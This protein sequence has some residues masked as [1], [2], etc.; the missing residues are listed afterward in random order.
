MQNKAATACSFK[1]THAAC[2]EGGEVVAL[3]DSSFTLTPEG[4]FQRGTSEAGFRPEP[5]LSVIH[6][7]HSQVEQLC[8]GEGIAL[9]KKTTVV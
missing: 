5:C 4:P 7:L 9:K 3:R 6:G 8:L 1:H 2:A